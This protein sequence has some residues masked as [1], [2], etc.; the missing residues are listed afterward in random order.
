MKNLKTDIKVSVIIPI[1]DVEKYID[2]CLNSVKNQS[3]TDF[4]VIM[5]NDGSP[6]KSKDIAQ[7]YVDTDER[8]TLINQENQGIA[9]VRNKGLT[10]AKGEYICFVDSDDFCT[11]DYLE[12][13]Y[14][15]AKKNNADIVCCAFSVYNENNS[16]NRMVN[17][18]NLKG[19]TYSNKQATN[20]VIRD[21][22]LKAY[23]WNKI[24]KRDLF[25]KNNILFPHMNC[26]EDA[27]VVPKLMHFANK[28][29]AI[30]DCCYY[31]VIRDTS[32]LTKHTTFKTLN[33]YLIIMEILR[34][35]FE[36]NN[37]YDLYK[38]SFRYYSVLKKLCTFKML[39]EVYK[40]IETHKGFIKNYI[41]IIKYVNYTI[42][43]NYVNKKLDG[44]YKDIVKK[45]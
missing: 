17:T 31:Y 42:S 45:Y 33:E 40:N 11:K 3:F 24:W 35:F 34:N 14:N 4:E 41:N 22:T 13:L 5:I 2:R 19:G 1:Y 29:V 27:V 12:K 39:R 23:L 28:L 32:A 30:D 10:L 36:E 25:I 18:R 15:T 6:D 26:F 9:N 21:Y 20:L 16:K 44:K 7:K 8:F 37:I 43:K 38:Y